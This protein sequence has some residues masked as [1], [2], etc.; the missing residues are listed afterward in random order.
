MTRTWFLLPHGGQDDLGSVDAVLVPL[1]LDL[2]EPFA[3][4]VLE[5]VLL[6]QQRLQLP[7]AEQDR[8]IL[9]PPQSEHTPHKH[10]D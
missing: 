6:N 7:V 10:L 9:R 3:R 4:H 1:G 8:T 2:V 5:L